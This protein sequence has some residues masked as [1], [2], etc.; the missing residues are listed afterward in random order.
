M[1][2]TYRESP[3]GVPCRASTLLDDSDVMGARLHERGGVSRSCLQDD[4]LV[5]TAVLVDGCVQ[6]AAF[7]SDITVVAMPGLGDTGHHPV[8]GALLVYP[9]QIVDTAL[10][11]DSIGIATALGD[12]SRVVPAP[13]LVDRGV[14]IIAGHGMV[15]VAGSA[16]VDRGVARIGRLRD[17]GIRVLHVLLN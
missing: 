10:V 17:D 4:G 13:V 7:L 16:L 8:P 12:P 5:F 3:R 11:D 6:G 9:G 1:H 14:L 2:G 15:P